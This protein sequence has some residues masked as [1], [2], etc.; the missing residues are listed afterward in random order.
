MGLLS[1]IFGGGGDTSAQDA[2]LADE[3]R[4]AEEER[5]KAEELRVAQAEERKALEL[6]RGNMQGGGRQGLMFGG[7]QRG[8]A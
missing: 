7:N 8:V 2:L 5:L 4:I 1:A 6:R 3:R